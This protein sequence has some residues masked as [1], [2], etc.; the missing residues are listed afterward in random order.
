MVDAKEIIGNV[1]PFAV[2][3]QVRTLPYPQKF[4]LKTKHEKIN[5]LDPVNHNTG[6]T[7]STNVIASCSNII[8]YYINSK[9]IRK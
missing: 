9:I 6:Y 4:N 3:V 5:N 8:D 7:S 2:S 1:K